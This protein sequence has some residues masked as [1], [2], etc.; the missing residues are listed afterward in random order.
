[1]PPLNDLERLLA[2][3]KFG[4]QHYPEMFR[5]LRATE[6]TFL[7]PYHPEMEGVIGLGNGD[8]L[9]PFVIWSS[10]KDGKRIPIFS[11]I[12]RAEEACKKTRARDNQYTLCEMPGQQLFEILRCQPESIA[13]NPATSLPAMMMD[14]EG[15]KQ[16]AARAVPDSERPPKQEGRV[17]FLTAADY[18]TKLVNSLFQY[19][20]QTPGVRAVWLAKDLGRTE[21]GIGYIA[22]VLGACDQ[23]KVREDIVIVAGSA[24]VKDDSLHV[25]FVEGVNTAALATAE[26]FVP[27]YAAPDY[28]SPSPLGPD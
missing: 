22:L 7:I 25:G 26:K 6:L 27:F 5:L 14:I 20:R 24:L 12:E 19:L 16:L 13:I 15:V 9:P 4:P 17:Q 28:R 1:M 23:K 21:P 18:P 8:P 10:P 11:S 2:D 3:P